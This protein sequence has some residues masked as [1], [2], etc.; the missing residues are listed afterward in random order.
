MK[1]ITRTVG[2][3]TL[4]LS[5]GAC[6]KEIFQMDA[7]RSAPAIFRYIWKDYA[8]HYG[9]FAVKQI[10]WDSVYEA[11]ED[12][13]NAATSTQQ[14]YDHVAEILRTLN[15]RHIS[16]YPA[17][18]P[19]L[20]T[21]SIDRTEDGTY[22]LDDY[23]FDVIKD[24]YLTD[25]KAP[26][27]VIQYGKLNDKVG[28]IHI[29]HFD[30]NRNEYENGLDAALSDLSGS[31]ALVVDIRDN[32]GGYDP[33]S[34]YVAGRFA[35]EQELYMTTRKK[36]GPGPD[37]F[38][39]TR[40]WYVSPTGNQQFTRPIIVL[41]S[42]STASA[43]ET[44]LLAMRTQ[45]HVRQMGSTTAGSFSDNPAFEA[46]NGW[47]Y[48]ISI[49]DFRA[50]DGRSYEGIGLRPEIFMTSQR[51]DWVAGKDLILEKA[52]ELLQ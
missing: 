44:Y 10:D 5:L 29:L 24:N 13:I 18:N 42:R 20:P 32:A 51:E 30:A 43:A 45:S 3:L 4:L 12:Q 49:G 31:Q 50:A 8:E 48:T 2:L 39:E 26:N 1:T 38:A 21:W 46:P 14:L 47:M 9:L 7:Q 40:E 41:T 19:E 34:Q 22:V 27:P 36:N 25:Y 16:L 33:N 37:D 15:D 23:H 28:Y 6:T 35:R 17:S 11:H 52:I